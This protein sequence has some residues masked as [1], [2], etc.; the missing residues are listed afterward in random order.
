MQQQPQQHDGTE[1][2]MVAT[3]LDAPLFTAPDGDDSARQAWRASIC[4]VRG[5][6]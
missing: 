2:V 1:G 5:G 3:V 6:G 4:S